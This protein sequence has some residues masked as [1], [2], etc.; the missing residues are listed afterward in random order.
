MLAAIHAI[1]I[2][3]GRRAK[4]VGWWATRSAGPPDIAFA[5][6]PYAC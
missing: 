3:V 2:T 4:H 1:G 5:D 6:P